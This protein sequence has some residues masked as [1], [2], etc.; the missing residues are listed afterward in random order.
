VSLLTDRRTY[1]AL[2]VVQ[3]GDAVACG[4][5]IPPIKKALDDVGLAEHLRPVL[6]V[7]KAASALGLLSVFRFP[8]LA[9]FT[10]F[11]LTVYFVLAVAFHIKAKDISPGLVAASSFLALYGVMTVKGPGA[12]SR[13]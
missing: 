13:R 3:A 5:R 9:R 1:A 7:V 6:P 2:A 10:T 8:G 11:V 12:V 4:L